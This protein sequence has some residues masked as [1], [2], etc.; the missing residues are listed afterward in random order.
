MV[1]CKGKTQN[2]TRC[3]REAVKGSVYCWQHKKN[4]Q[5]PKKKNSPKR[6]PRKSPNRKLSKS[7]EEQ[8]RK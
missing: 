5:S 4:N 8:Q 6:S 2:G 1:Q 3:T 7:E